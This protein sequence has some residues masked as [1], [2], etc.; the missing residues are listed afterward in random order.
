M[1]FQARHYGR[2]DSVR[3]ADRQVE[4]DDRE[5]L[6]PRVHQREN[7][8][9]DVMYSRESQ[10]FTLIRIDPGVGASHL[11]GGDVGPALVNNSML[12]PPTAMRVMPMAYTVRLPVT[13]RLPTISVQPGVSM[14]YEVRTSG[15]CV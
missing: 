1:H 6:G 3:A 7:G 5:L 12:R 8:R 2:A 10:A 9:V 15:S 11:A 13:S 4:I 14:M